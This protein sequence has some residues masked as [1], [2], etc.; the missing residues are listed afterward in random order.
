MANSFQSR[1]SARV[2]CVLLTFPPFCRPHE[3]CTPAEIFALRCTKWH[4]QE[5]PSWA[6]DSAATL[7]ISRVIA[8]DTDPLVKIG[9]CGTRVLSH[10]WRHAFL[11]A[12]LA[13]L[14]WAVFP[15]VVIR[16]A[17]CDD[18]AGFS[19]VSPGFL[20]LYIPVIAL[21]LWLE[22][23]VLAAKIPWELC[24]LGG[25]RCA[26][27]R[28]PFC[29]YLA[30]QLSLSAVG[31]ADL[32]TNG[33]VLAQIPPTSSCRASRVDGPDGVR[34]VGCS[35]LRAHVS[36]AALRRFH[37]AA[38]S[39]ERQLQGQG[40]PRV[41]LHGGAQTER[42]RGAPEHIRRHLASCPEEVWAHV[43]RMS[44]V[45]A[46]EPERVKALELAKVRQMDGA[47]PW[48]RGSLATWTT[49]S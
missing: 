47:D 46:R 24:C 38:A 17:V 5:L 12:C 19:Q 22:M 7:I 33:L 2:S 1:I 32:A 41:V 45:T 23:K 37:R 4:D 29:T 13:W 26:G 25:W 10:V 3:H 27:L 21:S 43:A 14:F 35:Q 40:I 44:T 16:F 42:Q 28:V 6:C 31:H 9:A 15:M 18:E 36:A 11:A 39:N 34:E 20:T 8:W 49:P 48:T 30:F